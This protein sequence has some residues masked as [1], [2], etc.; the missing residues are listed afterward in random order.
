VAHIIMLAIIIVGW[1]CDGGGCGAREK[2]REGRWCSVAREEA[3]QWWTAFGGGCGARGE[4]CDG[5]W[6]STA[7]YL[8][9]V[10]ATTLFL[11]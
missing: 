1:G 3:P 11:S 8:V 9:M 4:S 2:N 6:R 5:R 7:L 10:E